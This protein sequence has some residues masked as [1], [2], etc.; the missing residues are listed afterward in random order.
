MTADDLSDSLYYRAI[1]TNGR[2]EL[3]PVGRDAWSLP[4]AAPVGRASFFRS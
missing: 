4:D 3:W 1:R 2:A